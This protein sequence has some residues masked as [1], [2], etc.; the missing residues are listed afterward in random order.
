MSTSRQM[1]REWFERG[2]A[3]GKTHMIVVCDTFDHDDYPVYVCPGESSHKVAE[4]YNGKDMQRLMEVYDLR[5]PMEAQLA[6][7]RAWN[8]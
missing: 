2:V 7:R 1:I 5:K 4:A 3:Q 6:E 8:W